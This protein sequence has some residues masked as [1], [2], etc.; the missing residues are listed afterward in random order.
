[1]KTMTR[2]VWLCAGLGLFTTSSVYAQVASPATEKFY[3]NVNFGGQLAK[4]TVGSVVAKPDVYG[5][6]ATL[7]STQPVGAGAMFDVGAGY[8]I[9]HD[10][11]VGVVITSFSDTA[12]ATYTASVPN[13]AFFNALATST[14]GASNLERQEIGF[15]PNVTWVRPL[16][17]KIDISLGIGAAFISLSQRLINDFTVPAGTQ[18]AV[19][20]VADETG[21]AKGFFGQADFIYN[22]K[23]RYGIG[24]FFRYAGGKVDLSSVPDHNVGGAQAGAGIRLRF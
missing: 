23:P 16:T 19:P 2:M 11:Y 12:D 18:S 13:P 5:E 17:D 22:L 6:P 9:W 10:L 24:G 3:V 21:L 7:D 14:G 8:R 20:V 4:R 1:M 15:H